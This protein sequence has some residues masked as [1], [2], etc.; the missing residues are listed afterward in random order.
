[1]CYVTNG[2]VVVKVSYNCNSRVHMGKL[3]D[4]LTTSCT[5]QLDF[6]QDQG[7]PCEFVSSVLSNI[8]GDFAH[9]KSS[10]NQ[11]AILSLCFLV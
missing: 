7:M 2:S 1:M 4:F 5:T 3:S 6:L 8:Y 10:V 11:H 9:H